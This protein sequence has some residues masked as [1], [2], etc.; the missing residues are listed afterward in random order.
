MW[1]YFNKTKVHPTI[2][3]RPCVYMFTTFV[4]FTG[5]FYVAWPVRRVQWP[6]PWMGLWWSVDNESMMSGMPGPVIGA[7]PS[8]PLMKKDVALLFICPALMRTQC[9]QQ[10]RESGGCFSLLVC[11]YVC[12]CVCLMSCDGAVKVW[13][14]VLKSKG[15][16]EKEK[17]SYGGW[18]S[19]W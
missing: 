14:C 7:E 13:D 9:G 6:K 1:D 15:S 2:K 19:N 18:G 5:L 17:Y 10:Q 4:A 16:T 8:G 3:H 11:V 12:V